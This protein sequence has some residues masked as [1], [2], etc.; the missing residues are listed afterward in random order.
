VAVRDPAF[1]QIVWRKFQRNP[2]AIHYFY[3]IASEPASHCRQHFRARFEFYRK[4][5][6]LEL[7]D[8]LAEYLNRVFF[9]QIVLLSFPFDLDYIARG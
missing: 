2:I 3:P 8:N 5:S 4:H 1:R 7:L 9:W 6:G